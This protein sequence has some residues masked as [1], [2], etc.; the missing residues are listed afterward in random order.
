MG[1]IL[2]FICLPLFLSF[3]QL[4]PDIKY[5]SCV[6]GGGYTGSAWIYRLYKQGADNLNFATAAQD[7]HEAMRENA[8]YFF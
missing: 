4:A 2:V 6:S 3:F 7:L 5:V 1:F 8:G